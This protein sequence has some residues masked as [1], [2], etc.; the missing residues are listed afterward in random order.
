MRRIAI[1]AAVVAV[2]VGLVGSGLAI[3][4][5]RSGIVEPQTLSFAIQGVHDD[6]VDV[7]ASGDSAGDTFLAQ[8]ELLNFDLTKQLGAYDS[9]CVLET[10][11]PRLNHCTAT[12]L[13]PHG[14]VELSTRLDWSD[15]MPGFSLAVVGGTGR[16]DNVVGQA[17][18]TF[19]CQACPPDAHDVDTL[20]LYLLPSFERP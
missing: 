17:R 1:E 4:S 15:T 18:V 20:T 16:Y 9:A 10:V 12:A 14:T 19:G 13:L 3:A 5:S 2:V 7:G 8:A 11:V 6:T